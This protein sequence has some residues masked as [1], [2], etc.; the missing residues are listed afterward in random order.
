Y[1]GIDLVWYGNQH[2]LEHDFLIAPGA[3]PSR[4][5]LSFSGTDK[6]SIDGEG[7]LV[8]RAGGEDLRLLKP[9]AWQES[10]DSRR[11]VIC[12]YRIGE[13]NQVEFRLGDYDTKL[14][15]FIDPVLVYSTYI[16]GIGT[17]S[18][19][20]IAVDGEGAA[21]ISGQTSS[22]DFPANPIQPTIRNLPDAY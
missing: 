21:Y 20:D 19:L 11:T 15:L 3:D 8:L 4:I 7:A 12:D 17:D 18:G 1:P 14:P 6:M 5:K 16:G 13:M 10:N 9:L 22:S 2:L